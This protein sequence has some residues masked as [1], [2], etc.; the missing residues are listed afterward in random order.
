MNCLLFEQ[1]IFVWNTCMILII[2]L[3]ITLGNSQFYALNGQKTFINCKLAFNTAY[4]VCL[5]LR[6]LMFYEWE[7]RTPHVNIR[8]ESSGEW[9][10]PWKAIF[11][12][13]YDKIFI[14]I[15]FHLVT[16]TI[17]RLKE[18]S[19]A[20]L[21]R[22]SLISIVDCYVGVWLLWCLLLL[23]ITLYFDIES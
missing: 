9:R 17:A 13:N 4:K 7:N 6:I 1:A 11:Q 19:R 10:T 21:D 23:R 5:E 15:V 18:Q 2:L 14:S 8:V 3:W 12:G 16:V 20:S 22:N